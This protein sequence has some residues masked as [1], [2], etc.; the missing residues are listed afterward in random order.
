MHRPGVGQ[1]RIIGTEGQAGGWQQVHT[2]SA[3]G[4]AK[5]GT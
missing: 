4:T 1:T 5:D 3:A 2:R